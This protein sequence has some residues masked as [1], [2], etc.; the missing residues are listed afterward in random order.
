MLL[1]FH[2]GSGCDSC[3]YS[4]YKLGRLLIFIV[5]IINFLRGIRHDQESIGV[6]I[7]FMRVLLKFRSSVGT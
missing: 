7:G 1:A 2:T 4:R 6:F 5:E 3:F